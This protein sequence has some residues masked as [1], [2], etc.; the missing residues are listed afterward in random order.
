LLGCA[1]VDRRQQPPHQRHAPYGHAAREHLRYPF[2]PAFGDNC[3]L[4]GGQGASFGL[5][6]RRHAQADQQRQAGKEVTSHGKIS[7]RKV[8]EA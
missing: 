8:T 6:E 3:R 5:G 1:V 7:V 4:L 2:F